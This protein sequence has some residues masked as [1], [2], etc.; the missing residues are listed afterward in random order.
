M[1]TLTNLTAATAVDNSDLFYGLQGANSRK[2]TH[3]QLIPTV[4]WCGTATN[5]SVDAITITTDKLAPTTSAS[6]HRYVFIANGTTTSTTPT[7]EINGSGNEETLV[8]A[9][10][11]AL[12][13]GYVQDGLIY[14]VLVTGST[15]RIAQFA[16]MAHS[17]TF[18]PTCQF[19]T[20]GDF[21]PTYSTQSG[22]WVLAG[23]VMHFAI[24]LQFTANA[25]TTPTGAFEIQGLPIPP[26]TVQS[27]V[28]VG[29]FDNFD[30]LASD[31]EVTAH[32]VPST[33]EVQFRVIADQAGGGAVGTSRIPAST[34]YVI[35]VSGSYI[36][37]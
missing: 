32:V 29:R 28:T 10:T 1:T 13:V 20:N 6:G 36:V 22:R 17:E 37:I 14:E 16:S 33:G 19:E 34:S 30:Y 18:T 25:Y 11:S 12:P 7:I 26:R 9:D 31:N 2:F 15:Y 4:Y 35:W 24:D 5:Q 3:D 21:S 8:L 23:G 27:A